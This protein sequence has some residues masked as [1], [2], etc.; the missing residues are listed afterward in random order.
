MAH[1]H[2]VQEHMEVLGSDGQH[3]GVVDR[4]EDG[5]I[6]LTKDDPKSDGMHHYIPSDWIDHVDE[7][8]HLNK[9]SHD[10]MR[11]WKPGAM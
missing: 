9:S 10:A 2:Q 5:S 7:H 11:Q 8:V 6:K 3:V 1:H 4:L